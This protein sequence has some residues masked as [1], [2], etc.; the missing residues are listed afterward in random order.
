MR[1]VISLVL[2]SLLLTVAAAG[3]CDCDPEY[4]G[5]MADSL[6]VEEQNAIWDEN[7]QAGEKLLEEMA[8]C[9]KEDGSCLPP[10]NDCNIYGNCSC[11]T[12]AEL[13]QL[14]GNNSFCIEGQGCYQVGEWSGEYSWNETESDDNSSGSFTEGSSPVFDGKQSY[15]FQVT[16]MVHNGTSALDE[17]EQ[18]LNPQFAMRVGNKTTHY[19]YTQKTVKLGL[20]RSTLRNK[21]EQW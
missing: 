3:M 9:P 7:S 18:E 1:L 19:G 4:N 13:L 15:I 8:A 5:M 10:Y 21:S 17:C 11:Y 16:R 14:R 20:P 2:A 12:A 6:T